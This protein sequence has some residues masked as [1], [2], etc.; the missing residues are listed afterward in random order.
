MKAR[1]RKFYGIFAALIFSFMLPASA[2]ENLP[3]VLNFSDLI[4][5]PATGLNDGKGE[6]VIVTVWG[7]NLGGAQGDSRVYFK[8]ENGAIS[9]AAYIYYWKNADGTYAKSV[10]GVLSGGPANLYESHKMQ[11]IAFSIPNASLGLGEIYVVV[12]GVQSNS[13]AFTVRSGNIYHVKYD[14]DNTNSGSFD[15]PWAFVNGFYKFR[16]AAAKVAAGDTVYVHDGV[17]D[18]NNDFGGGFNRGIYVAGINSTLSNQTAFVAYPGARV[19]MRGANWG[20]D[21]NQAYG[22]VFSKY[23]VEVGN[24]DLPPPD[25]N[26][27]LPTGDLTGI[28]TSQNGR[29]VANEIT[30]L[31][32][33]CPSGAAGAISGGAPSWNGVGNVKIL[34]NYVHHF[35]CAQSSDFQHVFY[36]TNRSA[37][38]SDVEAWEMGWNYLKNNPTL[39]GLHNY[40]EEESGSNCGD[41][42]GTLLIHNN[43]VVNQKGYAI[44][45]SASDFDGSDP[46]W[47][48][49]VK[50]FNNVFKNVGHGPTWQK[51]IGSN[52]ISIVDGGLSGTVEIYNN[53]VYEWSD[54]ENIDN[55]K[56]GAKSGHKTG[57]ELGGQ[58][59]Y[60]TLIVNNNL[61]Y[62]PLDVPFFKVAPQLQNNVSGSNNFWYYSG[63]NP[64]KAVAPSWD[65]N[66]FT[67]NPQVVVSATGEV[68]MQSGSPLISAGLANWMSS[69][70]VSN[71]GPT[72]D[73]VG[74]PRS[75]HPAVGAKE[76]QLFADDD[77]DQ[78]DAG[79]SGGGGTLH[80]ALLLLL[81]SLLSRFPLNR[82]MPGDSYCA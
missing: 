76:F 11:E 24:Y 17:V 65:A 36:L 46:C 81:L 63:T 31:E 52:S 59:D 20:V 73:I 34:G 18:E 82:I 71:D 5:G 37:G 68:I 41:V 80:I 26:T 72:H 4:S 58:G 54:P 57:L 32:G 2:V 33:K 9:E 14:G 12:D 70:T 29:I 15:A 45:L 10:D 25:S 3:P 40:D 27:V 53:T 28:D 55:S 77:G 42:T 19:T 61:F 49:D 1:S 47:S 51:D 78:I 8:D 6:G 44:T 66:P 30:N 21:I 67:L 50:I 22:I 38:A 62:T 69:S 48:A 16:G 60:V 7:N 56:Y 74:V 64:E 35:G 23:V 75:S 43:V 39:H 13:L 79:S